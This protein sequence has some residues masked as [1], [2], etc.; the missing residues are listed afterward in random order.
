MRIVLRG[1]LLV[2]CALAATEGIA[3]PD[4]ASWRAELDARLRAAGADDP[5]QHR[6]AGTRWLR[7]DRFLHD[8]W[9]RAREAGD[10]ERARAVLERMAALDAA[11]LGRTQDAVASP[12]GPRPDAATCRAAAIERMLRAPP[13][14]ALRPPDE[15]VHWRR[16][17]G[18]YPLLVPFL[19]AGV[20]R[21]QEEERAAHAAGPPVPALRF[22][23]PAASGAFETPD[24]VARALHAA[25]AEHALGWPMPPAP[26]LAQL[27]L[28]F[29]PELAA[30]TDAEHDRPGTLS[31][32]DGRPRVDPGTPTAEWHARLVRWDGRVLLQLVYTFW[33]TERPKRWL[34]DP[35]GGAVDGIVWRVTLAEDGR[36]LLWDSVH[37]CGCFHTVFLPEGRR[38][39]LRRTDPPRAERPLVFEGPAPAARVLLSYASGTHL[40]R[41]LASVPAA[42]ASARRYALRPEQALH[43]GPRRAPFDRHGLLAGTGRLERFFLWPSGIRSP[44]AM[45][46]RGRRAT[47]FVGHRHFDAAELLGGLLRVR[48]PGE[49][50]AL[51][52]TASAP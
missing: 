7:T 34:L 9:R 3:A 44:G 15:Y 37:P 32:E 6:L 31:G 41:H 52:R 42:P 4:C 26:V 43:E 49:A 11:V 45:R 29:A 1:L 24:A 39:V 20:A 27:A 25:A 14:E 12:A 2:S 19:R 38:L 35:Y 22:V 17:I 48:V 18:L 23:P 8:A 28:R 10:P 13:E 5:R 46:A 51:R 16:V 40:V 21:W 30:P 33:F 36:P 50:E 47:A